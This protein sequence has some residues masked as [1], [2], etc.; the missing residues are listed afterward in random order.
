M[1]AYFPGTSALADTATVGQGQE[2][3]QWYMGC[4]RDNIEQ[5]KNGVDITFRGW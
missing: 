1:L 2:F 3:Y 5:Y 4:I